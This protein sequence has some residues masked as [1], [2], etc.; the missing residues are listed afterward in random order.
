MA[1]REG[2][3]LGVAVLD[4]AT[5][6]IETNAAGNQALRAASVTKLFTVVDLLVR[7]PAGR[8]AAQPG[9]EERIRRALGPSDDEAMN[10]LWSSAGGA[11]GIERVAAELGLTAT[12]PPADRSQWGETTTSARDV[13]AVLGVVAD[14]LAPAD[15]DLVLSSLAAAP[16]IAA[17]GFDQ[18]F[19]LL[20]PS[21]RGAALAKQGWLC[22]LESSVDLH[23][24]GFPEPGA[25]YGLAL[26]SNQTSGYGAARRVLDDAA[27][28][29][30]AALPR[31]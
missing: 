23:S 28:A 21:S 16:P 18:A 5:G 6:A 15:R 13:A 8:T 29:A 31:E 11:A 19:G 30:R 4:R 14:R 17:D 3:T 2:V 12:A 27:V 20:E 26:M 24:V 22:C 9:D 1:A 10:A 7:R 25:R